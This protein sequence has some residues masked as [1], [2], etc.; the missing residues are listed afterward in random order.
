VSVRVHASG[1]A[2]AALVVLAALARPSRADDLADAEALFRAG[3]KAFESTQYAAAADAFEQAYKK[4]PLPAIAFTAAQAERLQY[5]ID[6]QPDRL[7]RAV[8]LYHQYIDV[9]KTGGRVADA[10]SNL[11]QIEPLLRELTATGATTKDAAPVALK[12]TRLV[13]IADIAGARATIDNDTGPVP[14]VHDVASGEHT[15]VVAADGYA[16]LTRKATAIDGEMVPVE[17]V[18]AP[19]PA[20]LA[21]PTPTGAEV[22]VDGRVVGETPLASADVTAGKHYIAITKR[23]YVP[24]ARELELSRGAKLTVDPKFHTTRQRRAVPW[25]F[26]IGGALVVATGVAALLEH[27]SHSDALSLH[28]ELV[29]GGQDPSVVTRYND[30]LSARTERLHATEWLGGAAAAVL[31]TTALLYWFDNSSAETPPPITAAVGT[32]SVGVAFSGRF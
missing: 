1:I 20:T 3:Q 4:D 19:L 31:G 13:V 16:T 2:L 23:G 32:T 15:I 7:V 24:Y 30:A 12:A 28:A 6:N 25:V 29:T 5:F 17:V 21:V 10:V 8:T 18:L 27:S 9:Q 22:R 26:G 14:F 11:A